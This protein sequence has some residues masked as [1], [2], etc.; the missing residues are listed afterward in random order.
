MTTALAGDAAEAADVTPAR[1]ETRP[2]RVLAT[3][4]VFEPG[5][6][7]GGVIRSVA[8]I[9]DTLPEHVELILVT[10]DRDLRA[11]EPYPG[12]SGQWVNR[13]RSRVFYLDASSVR[14]WLGLWRQLRKIRFD[15]LYVNSLWAFGHTVVP[16]VAARFGLIRPR[17]ILIAPRGELA[18]GALAL[19][20]RKKRL[21]LTVWRPLLRSMDAKWHASSGQEAADIRAVMWDADVE[22]NLDQPAL[23]VEPIAPLPTIANVVRLVFIS[24]IVPIKRLDLVLRALLTVPSP[25]A[26][27]VYGPLEDNGYWT[28]CRAIIDQLPGTV[29]V[30]YRGEL[31]PSKVRETFSQYDAFIFPTA[32]ENFG[33]VIAESLSASC[34]VICSDQTPWTDCLDKGAG[35][36]IRELTVTLLAREIHR[37]VA[38]NDADR[39]RARRLSGEIYRSWRADINDVNV[40]EQV[41]RAPWT[42]SR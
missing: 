33:H 11:A 24:R 29:R 28:R 36:A 19:K 15:L 26:F 20:T 1:A 2:F 31:P 8:S 23:S 40:L 22:I 3:C 27:D 37:I 42:G 39:L 9:V 34:P 4:A 12:L 17:K 18:R 10:S 21:F 30:S 13:S 25:V 35:V 5:F 14:Q 16:V 6:R 32:G 38:M 7:G 41:R